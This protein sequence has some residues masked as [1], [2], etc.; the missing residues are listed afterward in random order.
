MNVT[1][2]L[3]RRASSAPQQTAPQPE[4]ELQVNPERDHIADRYN[5]SRTIANY[6]SGMAVGAATEA[7]T[8]TVQAPRLAWEITEN[9]WQA[10]TIG[11]NL[12]ILGT[13]AAIPAAALSIPCGPLYGVFQG[14]SQVRHSGHQDGLLTKD[15]SAGF[16]NQVMNVNESGEARTMTGKLCNSLEELGDKPLAEG[17]KPFDV[18][19]LSPVFS[20][21]GGVV[22]SVLAVG[23]GGI[24]GFVAGAITM[25]KEMGDAVTQEGLSAGQRV[26]KFLASPLNLVAMGPALAW[27]SFKEAAP[28][29]F[30]DGW[31]HGP[32]KPIIDTG[33]I[34]GTLAGSVIKEAWER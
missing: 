33:K 5:T 27:N 2:A 19:I 13:L 1:S 32:F 18:P 4:K 25:G 22:S 15:T 24:A 29:G 21:A 31:N 6:V 17:E 14:W 12:K 34:T 8:T 7:V 9:L 26:G 23:I 10:D 11:P 3:P 20:V 28:R 16:A 30:V